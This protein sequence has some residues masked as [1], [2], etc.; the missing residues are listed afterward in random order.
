MFRQLQVPILGILENMSGF[1]CPHCGSRAPVFK[2]GGGRRASEALQVPFLGAVPLDPALCQAGDG[3]VP[4]V[5]AHPASAA[6]EAFRGA[7][8]ALQATIG[9]GGDGLP[10][11]RME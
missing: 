9:R 11:I 4:I 5:A 8:R 2:E 7:S 6:A 1:V 10:T 3:G